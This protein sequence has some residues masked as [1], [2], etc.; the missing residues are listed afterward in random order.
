MIGR[1]YVIT[2]SASGIGAA[3]ASILRDQGARVIG[4][5]LSDADIIADLSTPAGRQSLV[6]QVAKWGHI[7]AVL[8]SP[9]FEA[10]PEGT[11]E[12]VRRWEVT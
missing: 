2:G 10:T 1:R 8:A 5:D 7:H 4:C 9:I 6:A 12:T 3:T 11:A